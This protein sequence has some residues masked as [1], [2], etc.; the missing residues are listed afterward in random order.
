MTCP[1]HSRQLTVH[2]RSLPCRLAIF[3]TD[4]FA[5]VG[6]NDSS[7]RAFDLRSLTYFTLYEAPLPKNCDAVNSEYPGSRPPTS[8]L[9]TI[10]P[11]GNSHMSTFRVYGTDE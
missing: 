11:A 3:N 8:S 2:D 4:R 10:V 6:A 5:S 9:L 1:Q 7:L